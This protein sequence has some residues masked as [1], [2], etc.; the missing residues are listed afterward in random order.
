MYSFNQLF[1]IYRGKRGFTSKDSSKLPVLQRFFSFMTISDFPLSVLK[2]CP[3]YVGSFNIAN[4]TEKDWG[5]QSVRTTDVSVHR[6]LTVALSFCGIDTKV[7]KMRL[8]KDTD[9]K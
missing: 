1:L 7:V 5:L 8:N 3:F 2:R 4:H 6:E 9:V